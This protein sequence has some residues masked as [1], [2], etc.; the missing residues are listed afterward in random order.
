MMTRAEVHSMRGRRAAFT[1][2]E[3]LVVIGIIALL[4]TITVVSIRSVLLEAR[5]SSATNLVKTTLSNAR[6][7]ALKDN[8]ATGV[9]F[10]VRWDPAEGGEQV[11]ELL[12]IRPTGATASVAALDPNGDETDNAPTDEFEAVPGVPVR[13]LPPGIKV[14]APFYSVGVGSNSLDY[15]NWVTQPHF[16]PGSDGSLEENE[17]GSLLGV[18]FSPRGEVITRRLDGGARR[19]Y[20][21]VDF[22]GDGFLNDGDT[23]GIGEQWQYDEPGDE[24]RVSFAPFIAVFDDREAHS[25]FPDSAFEWIGPGNRQQRRDDLSQYINENADRIHFNRHTGVVMR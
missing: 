13:A 14:A 18:L 1:T 25:F 21:W 20:S 4:T 22:D 16:P 8:Q 7:L 6:A 17:H 10:V 9:I 11:V 5:V 15:E 19:Q 12:T 2:I 24:P 23:Q 3:L